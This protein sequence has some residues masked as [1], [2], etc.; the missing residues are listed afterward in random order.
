MVRWVFAFICTKW[1]YII[2]IMNPEP[3]IRNLKESEIL[4]WM[5]EPDPYDPYMASAHHMATLYL[6]EG[7]VTLID[8]ENSVRQVEGATYVAPIDLANKYGPGA[9][10][11][12]KE[13]AM[14]MVGNNNTAEYFEVML[15]VY[16]G[17]P[18]LNLL[19]IR[20]KINKGVPRQ[21]F[22]Y[23]SSQI[24]LEQVA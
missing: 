15:R 17:N 4:D 22:G 3:Y 11:H 1:W 21:E 7:N 9:L 18:A 8:D 20:V 23:I 24:D 14:R 16:M 2:Y 5:L 10:E 19:H 13:V 12:A 6:D